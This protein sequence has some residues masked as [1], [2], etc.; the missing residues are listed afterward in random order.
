M[1]YG[2]IGEHLTHSFSKE[3]HN[4]LADYP[5]ILQEIP[6]DQLEVF[7][8]KRDFTAINVTIPYKQ[9]VIPHLKT[10]SDTARAIGAVNTVVNKNGELHGYNTD[11]GG[12]KAL[13]ERAHI[14]LDGK[15]VLI[16][17]TG[18]TSRTAKAVAAHLGAASIFTVSRTAKAGCLTYQS[19]ETYHTDADIIINTTPCGMYPHGNECP[20]D[21]TAFKS[22]SG[23]VDVIYNPLQ[24]LLVRTAQKMGIPAV[25]GLYML[26]MQAVLACEIFT[27]KAIDPQV[28]ESVYQTILHKKQNI[29]L[30]GMPAAG[31][32]TVGKLLAQRLDRP[33]IDTDEEIL[34]VTGKTP[35]EIITAQGEPA[36]RDIESIVICQA[37]AQTGAVIATGGGAVLRQQN[38]DALRSN[39][40]I[41]FI[42][43]SLELLRP[44]ADRPLS[45]DRATLE[46]RFSERFS[47][48]LATADAVIAGDDTADTVAN[49]VER[50][51]LN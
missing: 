2:C 5:Y 3:I 34:R 20:I 40:K 45:S 32:T 42:N 16:L 28:A 48:Y 36:F 30:T 47:T 29:V 43:R 9:A 39:G 31:K 25:G 18:G 37:A 46:K 38:V 49:L 10:I 44:T 13:I 35:Q 26:V 14:S 7:L 50:S 24:T 23:V 6:T 51:F 12:M 22:L 1:Q 8:Q 21:L 4:L 17:G 33:F 19:A 27:E 15:K 41:F 11:F